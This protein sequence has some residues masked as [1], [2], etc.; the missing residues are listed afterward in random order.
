MWLAQ[1]MMLKPMEQLR[2]TKKKKKKKKKKSSSVIV[3]Y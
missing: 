3:F 2:D 1:A